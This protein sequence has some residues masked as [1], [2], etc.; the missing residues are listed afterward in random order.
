MCLSL[1]CC[2]NKAINLPRLISE[3]PGSACVTGWLSEHCQY[4]AMVANAF[5]WLQCFVAAVKAH[6]GACDILT[7]A[8][9]QTWRAD[10]SCALE[11]WRDHGRTYA[12]WISHSG[13]SRIVQY[14]KRAKRPAFSPYYTSC[15]LIHCH[16]HQNKYDVTSRCSAR[17]REE[18]KHPWGSWSRLKPSTA[19][20]ST[21]SG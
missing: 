7:T 6:T 9:W 12:V 15:R 8:T 21:S 3:P 17:W 20:I 16:F 10:R 2:I 19:K 13:I 11:F 14:W 4:I 5:R 1:K 18:S